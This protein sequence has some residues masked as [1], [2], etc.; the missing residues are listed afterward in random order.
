MQKSKLVITALL[1]VAG[2]SYSTAH[3]QKRTDRGTNA[4]VSG[5][6]FF[7]ASTTQTGNYR[8]VNLKDGSTLYVAQVQAFSDRAVRV[9]TSSGDTLQLTLTDQAKAQLSD[10]SRLA[11]YMNNR[12]F[13]SASVS[14][15]SDDGQITI[16]GLSTRQ[17]SQITQV[18]QRRKEVV[19]SGGVITVVPRQFT[20]R[21][22]DQITVDMFLTGAQGIRAYQVKLDITGG[23]AG[24]LNRNL[25]ILDADRQDFIFAGTEEIIKGEDQVNGRI[26]AVKIY[27]TVDADQRVYLGSEIFDVSNDAHGTFQ[28]NVRMVDSL[29]TDQSGKSL[30]FRVEGATINID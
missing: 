27:G 9:A 10:S 25:M 6:Q 2:M 8:S 18:I 22:G 29:I 7:K 24:T 15:I 16:S 19:M 4:K 5:L 20:A 21:A 13:G 23:N 28:V 11:I 3:A 17:L 26:G 1:L 30:N 14:Q 12:F